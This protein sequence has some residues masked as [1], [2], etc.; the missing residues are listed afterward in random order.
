VVERG[1]GGGSRLWVICG[2]NMGM[3]NV[4]EGIGKK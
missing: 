3:Y 1:R 2:E 4:Q